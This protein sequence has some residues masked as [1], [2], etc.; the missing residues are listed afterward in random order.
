MVIYH[1]NNVI[2]MKIINDDQLKETIESGER[3]LVLFS[4]E[5]CGPCKIIK[6]ALEKLEGEISEELKIV[7]ADIG[8]AEKS[9]KNFNIRN[10]PTCVII[11]G[12]NEIARFS[13]V[14]NLDQIKDF[15]KEHQI[16]N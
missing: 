8:E 11:E 14:K 2:H 4:A 6:P 5:W 13:G 16:L 3:T 15:L 12:E 1:V 9:T 7:K 10:I